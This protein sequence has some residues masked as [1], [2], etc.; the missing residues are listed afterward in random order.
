MIRF[1]YFTQT[2]LLHSLGLSSLGNSFIGIHLW[3]VW[4]Q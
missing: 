1:T 2:K 4:H 3:P